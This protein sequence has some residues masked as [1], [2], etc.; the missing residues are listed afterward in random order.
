MVPREMFLC[1]IRITYYGFAT[2]SHLS[3]REPIPQPNHAK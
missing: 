2:L 1:R 3:E